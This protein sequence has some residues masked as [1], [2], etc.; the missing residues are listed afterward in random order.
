MTGVTSL[1][2]PPHCLV[3]NLAFPG[4]AVELLCDA[5]E[6]ALPLNHPP[7][8][9]SCGC[10]LAQTGLDVTHC[11]AC[12]QRPLPV[13]WSRAACRYEG[14]AKTCV[15]RLKYERQIGLVA[16]MARRMAAAARL[17]PACSAEALIPVP[18]HPVRQRERSFNQ[19]ALLAEAVGD[20]LGLPAL[21]E[22]LVRQRQTPPQTSL[23]AAARR[24]NVARAFAVPQPC[25]PLVRDK[26]LTLVD[27]VL[28]TGA[29]IGACAR[30]LRKAGAAEVG[31]LVFAHG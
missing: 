11:L 26:R 21:D 2:Y 13:A 19:A 27:D 1:L 4:E 6:E 25:I 7:W 3:C 18:L 28:T 29:T 12:R 15:V 8:C 22:I 5:C 30:A 24:R 14:A 20:A 9:Q 16:P 23:Q 17:T 10:S 31:A